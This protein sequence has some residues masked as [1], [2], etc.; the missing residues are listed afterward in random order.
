MGNHHINSSKE[1]ILRI[2]STGANR[3][4]DNIQPPGLKGRNLTS[5]PLEEELL[6]LSNKGGIWKWALS[7]LIPPT[8][9]LFF[10][11]PPKKKG[12]ARL[13][14][15]LSFIKLPQR[16]LLLP[17]AFGLSGRNGLSS[18]LLVSVWEGSPHHIGSLFLTLLM[19]SPSLLYL[20]LH[21]L[22]ISTPSCASCQVCESGPRF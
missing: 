5:F 22:P 14:N 10:P 11:P 2:L 16:G 3:A 15:Q 18:L 13:A 4:C 8:V 9:A 7:P 17:W 20:Y 21:F 1:E 6:F 19:S 12:V